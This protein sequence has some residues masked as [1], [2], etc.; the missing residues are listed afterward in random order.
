M[1]LCLGC[2]GCFVLECC[3]SIEQAARS[4]LKNISDGEP[5]TCKVQGTVGL[6]NVEAQMPHV[7]ACFCPVFRGTLRHLVTGKIGAKHPNFEPFFGNVV[8]LQFFLIFYKK[9]NKDRKC[10][11][12][13][14]H[15]VRSCFESSEM[16]GHGRGRGRGQLNFHVRRRT[17]PWHAACGI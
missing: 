7:G 11:L 6:T 13:K 2:S 16:D 10:G 8:F 14:N 1:P 9:M 4:L 5:S 15:F 3:A 17:L 12:V